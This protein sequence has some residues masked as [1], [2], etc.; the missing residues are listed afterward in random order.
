MQYADY[1][2]WQR[3]WLQGEVLEEQLRYW[4]EKLAGRAAVLELPTDHAR[5]RGAEP[6]GGGRCGGVRRGADAGA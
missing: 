3:E 4:E 1:A 6:G 5:A 2:V